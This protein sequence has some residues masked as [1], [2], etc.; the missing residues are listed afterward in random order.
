MKTMMNSPVD[1]PN[2]VRDIAERSVERARKAFES[3]LALARRVA[4]AAVDALHASSPMKSVGAHM[5]DYAEQN[6]NAEFE[7]ATKLVRAKDPPEAF[8]LESE[9]LKPQLV[10]LETPAKDLDNALQ[11]SVIPG[12]S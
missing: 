11:R 9:Y 1:I 3:F 5:L 10:A 8:A 6:V 4:E 2:V 7:L 12:S